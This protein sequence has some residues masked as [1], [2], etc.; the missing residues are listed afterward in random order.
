[1][2]TEAVLEVR[3]NVIDNEEVGYGAVYLDLDM[4]HPKSD[5]SHICGTGWV[6]A[7]L[8]VDCLQ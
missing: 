5:W 3:K 6:C 4:L 1:M 2:A 8:M 7:T